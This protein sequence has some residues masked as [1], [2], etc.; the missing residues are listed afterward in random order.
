MKRLAMATEERG[1]RYGVAGRRHLRPA[2]DAQNRIQADR[3]RLSLQLAR[4]CEAFPFP[5]LTW[6][7]I[8]GLPVRLFIE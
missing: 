2:E 1:M 5:D 8:R 3:L 6:N 4:L 7:S